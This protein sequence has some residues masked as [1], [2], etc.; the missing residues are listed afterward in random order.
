[1]LRGSA[2]MRAPSVGGGLQLRLGQVEHLAPE[3]G[4]Q[5]GTGVGVKG[6]GAGGVPGRLGQ[7]SPAAASS[8]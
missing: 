6:L 4:E 2:V 3:A 7:G 1:M 8:R 5:G